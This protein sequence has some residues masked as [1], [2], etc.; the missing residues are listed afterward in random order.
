MKKN[1]FLI[2]SFFCIFININAQQT[3][4]R[5][6]SLIRKGI[7]LHDKGLYKE[8]IDVYKEVLTFN[9]KSDVALYE[10]AYSYF[11]MK[12]F[13]RAIEYSDQ[14]LKIL[15]GKHLGASV[16][17]GSSLDYQ[18]KEAESVKV[19]DAA[20][21]HYPTNYLLYFNRGLVF[22]KEKDY[23]K[24]QQDLIQAI[25]VKR[26]H[27]S[28]HMQLGYTMK[29]QKKKIESILCLYFFL[30]LEANTPRAK[31]AYDVL[32][33]NYAG[34][35]SRDQNNPKNINIVL[36]STPSDSEF[37]SFEI[38]LPLLYSAS[39]LT[40]QISLSQ[41]AQFASFLDS[42]ISMLS[43]QESEDVKS[44]L[45]REFYLPFFSSLKA[46]GHLEAFS[47]YIQRGVSEEARVWMNN[48]SD[49]LDKFSD[50]YSLN[51]TSFGLY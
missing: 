35:V 27:A 39:T 45:W 3:D 21:T 4:I 48:N 34:S 49:K 13:D 6:D 7:R 10:I 32:I 25:E 22:N 42:L 9:P 19:F 29:A 37:A 18:G 16:V 40:D 1:L 28:S 26:D 44:S 47:Y 2:F 43:E 51:A 17:K 38:I 24:A 31:H 36:D 20:I 8:A 30:F 12:D 46:E 5:A 50:W 15:D 41:E 11:E 23:L 33:E 14:V